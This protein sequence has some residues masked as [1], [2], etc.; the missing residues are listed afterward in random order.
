VE[1]DQLDLQGLRDQEVK[2]DSGVRVVHLGVL[3][4]L[5]KEESQEGRDLLGHK[6][7]EAK[8]VHKG[9]LVQGGQLGQLVLQ[10]LLEQLVNVVLLVQ[11]EKEVPQV[12][13]E[14]LV[15]LGHL[16]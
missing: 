4:H 15:L 16:E 10:E 8:E 6:E 3:V 5:V 2:Q 11:L 7:R 9:H 12:K 13:G 14:S 1:Q